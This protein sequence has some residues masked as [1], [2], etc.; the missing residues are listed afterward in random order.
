LGSARIGNV[1][2]FATAGTNGHLSNPRWQGVTAAR[3]RTGCVADRNIHAA[4][5]DALRLVKDL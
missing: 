5:Y 3:G 1:L 4:V 2:R